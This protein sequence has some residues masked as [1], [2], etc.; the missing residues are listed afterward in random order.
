M[1]HFDSLKAKIAEIEWNYPVLHARLLSN[2][3]SKQV[4]C[5]CKQAFDIFTDRQAKKLLKIFNQASQS[6][7]TSNI[8]L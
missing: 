1:H 3:E 4:R 2:Q 7:K 8:I 5:A 6:V